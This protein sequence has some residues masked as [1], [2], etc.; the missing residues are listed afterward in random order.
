TAMSA[1]VVSVRTMR[2]A[3]AALDTDNAPCEQLDQ[4]GNELYALNQ[5]AVQL[6]YGDVQE[7]PAFRFLPSNCSPIQRYKSLCCLIY[8]CSEGDIPETPLYQ[9]MRD[10]ADAMAREIVSHLPE[11]DQAIWD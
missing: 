11:Y 4:L 1:F 6:R 5:R 2:W 7:V 3:I 10:R 8:Q 9:R